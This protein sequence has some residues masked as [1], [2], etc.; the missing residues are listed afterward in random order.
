MSPAHLTK[1]TAVLLAGKASF[2]LLVLGVHS[3]VFSPFRC[4]VQSEL[5][6]YSDFVE[7]QINPLLMQMTGADTAGITS[8]ALVSSHVFSNHKGG[9]GK[10]TLLFHTCA[11]YAM[12]HPDEKVMVIDTTLR[13]DLSELLLGGDKGVA[14]KT[15]LR[16]VSHLRSTTK[17]LMQAAAVHAAEGMSSEGGSSSIKSIVAKMFAKEK[18]AKGGSL[19]DLEDHLVKVQE[20][21]KGIPENC[22]EDG[23]GKWKVLCDT[24]GDQGF[25]D[26]TKIAHALCDNC[27]IPLKRLDDAGTRPSTVLGQQRT[28]SMCFS[29]ADERERLFEPVHPNARG[30]FPAAAAGPGAGC[31]LHF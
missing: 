15:A 2:D 7:V 22:L 20:F 16:A 29:V 30:A 28:D 6:I 3:S 14:G 9:C 4:A 27:I 17:L 12:R 11:E 13:G 10:T 31:F 19:L 18:G 23:P 24:D 21:N 25:S 8:A 1:W 5:I 26:Y